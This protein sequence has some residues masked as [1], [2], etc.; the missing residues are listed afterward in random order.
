[1]L[2]ENTIRAEMQWKQ[3]DRA[4]AMVS[5][6]REEPNKVLSL[7]VAEGLAEATEAC[8]ELAGR[9]GACR[10]QSQVPVRELRPARPLQVPA[11]RS[12]LLNTS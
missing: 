9:V 4:M 7:H 2:A 5:W 3:L 8:C 1:M 11:D 12:Q 6:K 10:P